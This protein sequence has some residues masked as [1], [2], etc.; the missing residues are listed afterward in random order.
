MATGFAS[1]GVVL[2]VGVDSAGDQGIM[3]FPMI[4]VG[5]PVDAMSLCD[6]CV[7]AW[8]SSG[9]TLLQACIAEDAQINMFAGHGMLPGRIPSIN[10]PPVDDLPGSLGENACA[11]Q[12]AALVSWYGN[13]DDMSAGNKLRIARNFILGVAESMVDASRIVSALNTA[14]SNFAQALITGLTGD[15]GALWKR[16]MRTVKRVDG[17]P[18]PDDE[19][20]IVAVRNVKGKV[21]TQKGR[22]DPF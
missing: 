22:L 10:F 6:N 1:Q 19:I 7:A 16:G 12:V 2:Q 8:Q 18:D 21:A 17:V 15:E 3:V 4:N 9:A 20:P 11:A 5:T 13:P 14:L